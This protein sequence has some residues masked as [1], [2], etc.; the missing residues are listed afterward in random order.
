MEHSSND[1]SGAAIIEATA[2]V[3]EDMG[4]SASASGSEFDV[5]GSDARRELIPLT[6]AASFRILGNHPN[7]LFDERG[8][9]PAL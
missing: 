6:R 1:Y 3:I 2:E 7:R 4:C 5:K 8:V 9:I